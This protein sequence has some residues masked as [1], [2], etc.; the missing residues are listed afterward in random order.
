MKHLKL[1]LPLRTTLVYLLLGGLWILV[2]DQ[3][4]SIFL[5]HDPQQT[6]YQLLKGIFAILVSGALLYMLLRKDVTARKQAEEHVK[7]LAQLLENVNDAIVASDEQYI[8]RAWNPAAERMYGWKAEEVIGRNGVDILQTK[9]PEEDASTMRRQIAELGHYVG[10]AIQLRKD[11]TPIRVEVASKVLQDDRGKITGYVSVNR[12]ITERKRSNQQIAWLASFPERNPNPEVEID[13][14]GAVFYMN[15]A[16][17]CRFPDL[18]AQG[19]KHPWLAGLDAVIARFHQEGTGEQQREIQIGGAWYSQLIYYVL[20][21][22]RLRVYGADITQRKQAE[23]NIQRSEAMLRAI[24][25]QMP[26]GVTVRDAHT[27]GL[28]LSNARSREIMGALVKSVDQF[29]Q[30]HGFHP[31]GRPYQTEDWPVSRSIATGEI[32]QAEEITYERGNADR[33]VLSISSAPVRDEQGQIV[34]GVGVF[35]DIT[36]RKKAEQ[37]LHQLT[38]DLR[39]SNA[40]LEQFAYVASH[41]LQEPLR[42]VS[43]YMQLLSKRYQGK[44]DSDADEFIAYAVDG[45]K[46]MQ[47]LINDLLMYSRVGTRGKPLTSVSSEEALKAAIANLQFII[48]ENDVQL[49][50]EPMPVVQGDPV[51]LVMVF[52]NLLGNAIKFRGSEPPRIHVGVRQEGCEWMFSIRDNGIGIDPKFYDRIFVIFQRLNDRSKYPGTGIG[53]AICKRIVERHGGCIWVESKPGEGATFYF[54]L[55]IKETS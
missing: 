52:Q 10:E 46:R 53:L 14:T 55:P 25:D 48:E 45:A 34:M 9:F 23:E 21:A 38:E 13:A 44:L 19:F 40:E 27:G 47:I 26:S 5:F 11:G 39:R 30:Y 50:H 6:A 33:L 31:D 51:Q 54:T 42:M 41:D 2:S 3:I 18:P 32:V 43:S 17:Q 35:D 12:D 1:E 20:E 8:L 15:P 22:G 28:I 24:L 36:Q 4:L 49:T 16:A 29:G 7:Y 37:T